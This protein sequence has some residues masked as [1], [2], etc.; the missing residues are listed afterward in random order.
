MKKRIASYLCFMLLICG[1]FL[2]QGVHSKNFSQEEQL[3]L[4]GIGAFNDGFYDIAEKQFSLFIRDYSNHAK[5]YDICYLLGKT[6]LLKGKLKEAKSVFLKIANENK[7]FEYLDLTLF[8]LAEIE[9]KLGNGE[10]AKKLLSSVIR[11]FPRFEWIDYSYYLLG[12]L[13]I[14]SNRL[15]QAETSFKK[16]SLLSKN[17]ELI[18]SSSFWLGILSFKQKNYEAAA[19]Y[20]RRVWED[21]RSV[22]Q[23]YL[24]YVLFW[25]GEA[26][27]KLGRFND[28]KLN[29]KTF[30]ERF[31]NDSL[32]PEVSWRLGFCEY[33][34][35]NFRDSIDTFQGLKNQFKHLPLTLYTH[36]LLGEIFLIL[37]D[38]PSSIKEMNSILT[39]SQGNILSGVSLL[40]LFWDYIHLGE[41]QGANNALQ[42]LQKLNHFDDEKTFIQWLNA[43]LI[44]SQGKISDSLPYYFNILNTRFREKALSQIARGYFF[45]NKFR[46]AITNSDILFLEFPNSIYAEE[47]LFIKGESL[48]KLGDFDHALDTYDLIIQQNKNNLWQLFALTQTG[49]IYLFRNEKN[50][51][52]NSFTKII[53]H[54]PNHPLFYNAAL[55]LGNLHFKKNN[56]TEAIH[57]YS[58]V[59]KGN[60]L[61]LFGEAH[62][63][64]G[65]IFYQQGKY[66][67]AFTSFETAIGCLKETSLW[68]FLSQLEIGNLQRKWGKY[69]E[70]K[71]AYLIILDRSKDEEIKKA[72]KTLLN[73]LG[74]N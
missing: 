60:I 52:E 11:R 47:S 72:A 54:F 21:P 16:I 43:E 56:I 37:G 67:K 13:D 17:S 6:L 3:I 71:K 50:K 22:P 48:N 45:E 51:A 66:E 63:S 9:I 14:G 41:M 58:M 44:F 34:L 55:Q 38:Y 69:E 12:L 70:A 49:N 68:F 53:D 10:E 8:W 27:F 29:Y 20:F 61:E 31:K 26:Q 74:S 28:A 73:H 57:Y 33:R 19:N 46:E 24:K 1:I 62:F 23:E 4:V 42:R 40:I 39:K 15:T 2:A 65:E 59:L 18:G 32:V 7:N 30:C 5:V 25:L 35:G 64:L 36:Y